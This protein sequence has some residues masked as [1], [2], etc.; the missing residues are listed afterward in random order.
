V[1]KK[2][3]C[4]IDNDNTAITPLSNNR[5]WT[6]FIENEAAML[7]PEKD[8]WRKRFIYTLL[9]WAECEDSL[10]I[11]DFTIAMKMRRG[12]LYDWVA[13]YPDIKRAFEDA[14]L[15]LSSRYFKGALKRQFDK[16]TVFKTMH[17]LD[18]EW[19]EINSY[20]SNLKKEE[21]APSE[22]RYVYLTKPKVKSK[23][24]VAAERNPETVKE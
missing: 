4:K 19:L 1:C 15:M 13:K 18:P 8:D 20:W 17:K 21:A 14:K 6:S 12:T 9:T 7:F 11:T 23:E 3:N 16:D 2:T 10:T 5:T 24:E 22:I